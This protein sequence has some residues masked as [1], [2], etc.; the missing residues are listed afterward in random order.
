MAT[1]YRGTTPTIWYK[2]RKIDPSQIVEGFLTIRQGFNFRAIA[3]EKSI[4]DADIS[5]MKV[6]WDLSQSETLK[7]R[8]GEAIAYFNYL[9]N[10]GKRGKGKDLRLDVRTSG[11]DEV[12]TP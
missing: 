3:L 4:D 7:L 9:L 2:F 8:E 5:E 12:I 6:S 11:K 10:N 1:L